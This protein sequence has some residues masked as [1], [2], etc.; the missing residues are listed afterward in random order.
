MAYAS[1]LPVIYIRASPAEGKHGKEE[2]TTGKDE[3]V[4][5]FRHK[6]AVNSHLSSQM[7]VIS[8]ILSLRQLVV[9]YIA[10]RKKV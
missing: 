1:S 10:K 9:T 8:K 4:Q 7:W 2:K 5:E 3:A 6:S